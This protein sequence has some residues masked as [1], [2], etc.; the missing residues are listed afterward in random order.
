MN[1]FDTPSTETISPQRVLAALKEARAKLAA[2][3]QAKQ[4]RVAIVG[5][6]GRFPGAETI[7]R[8][9]QNL[10]QGIASIQVLNPSTLNET[11]SELS[12]ESSYSANYSAN[13][14]NAYASFADIAGFDAAF[15]GYSPR[16]AELLDPQHRVFLEC[17]WTALEHAGYDPDRYPGQIGVYAGAGLN[18]YL[19][20]LYTHPNLR[21]SVD[22]VQAVVSNV[23]GLMPTRVSYKL[24]LTG[25][26]C[27]I[28]TGCSTSLVA[29]HLACQ[30]LLNRECDMALAGG[31]S[32]D[33]S[34]QR[35][36]RYQNDGVLSPDG[37]CRAFDAAAQGTVFG[38]GA[39]LVVLKRL[40]EALRDGDSIYAVIKGSAINNDGA[41]KVGLTAPSVTGQA[42]V[43]TTALE[44]ANC[45]P[46]TI[47]YIEAHGTGTALG[48]P[49]EIAALTKAFRQYTQKQQFCAIGSLKTN[50]GHLD[51]AAGIAGL[52]K[53]A[54]ALKH[55]QIPP[56]LNFQSA[57]PQIDFEHSPFYVNTQLRNWPNNSSTDNSPRHAGVSSFGMGGTNA[58]LI[59]EEAPEASKAIS[60]SHSHYL[61][62]LSAK[63]PSALDTSIQQLADHLTQHPDL[64]LADVAYTLQVGRKSFPYRYATV[65][66]T[67]P[68]AIQALQNHAQSPSP[69]STTPPIAFLFPGQGSQYPSM[70]RHLYDHEPIFRHT[71]DHCSSLLLSFLN[72]DLR[73]LLYPSPPISPL[74][75]LTPT[76]HAQPA[77]FVVEYAL[78]QLWRSW[79]IQPTAMIGHSLGE[80]VAAT[81]AGVFDLE[82]ALMIVATRAQLMQQCPAG[83]MLSVG[84]AESEV[85]SRLPA[86]LSIAAVNAPRACVV[87]GVP[88][89]IE[90][91]EQ[92]LTAEGVACRRLHTSHAF[93]SPLMASV[94][95]PLRER[96]KSIALH[97]PQLPFISNL[98]GTWITASEA[99]NPDYWVQH[100]RQ[101][102][103]FA[104]GITELLKKPG[105]VLLEVGPGRTLSTLSKQIIG[106]ATPTLILPSL[107]HPQ[108]QTSDLEILLHSLRQ[109]W[110]AGADIDCSTLYSGSQRRIPLPTYPFE[111]QRY[112][113][114]LQPQ[115]DSMPVQTSV[116]ASV[117][118]PD[119]S[120]WF[121][122]PSWSRST[123]LASTSPQLPS[124]GCW[125]IF[126]DS[127]GIAATLV[128]ALRQAGHTVISVKMGDRFSQQDTVYTID[129]QNQQDYH[130]LFTGLQQSGEPPQQIIHA[131][132]ITSATNLDRPDAGFYSLIALAQ[133]C[134]KIGPISIAVLT[135][136][137]FDLPGATTWEPL[138][139]TLLGACRVIRQECSLPCRIIE[140]DL[141]EVKPEH[142]L[143]ELLRPDPELA[144]AH[145]DQYRWIPIIEPIRL[146]ESNA[147]ENVN[148][149]LL[150]PHQTYLIAGDLVA[151]LGLIFAQCFATVQAKL[152]LIGRVGLPDKQ[153]WTN[154]LNTHG[155]DDSVSRYILSLQSLE[156]QGIELHCFSADLTDGPKL[157]AIVEWAYQQFGP[158]HAAVHADVM[159]DQASCLISSLTPAEIERQFRAKVIGLQVFETVLRGKVSG[160]YLLQ[161]SLSA[162]VGGVGFAAYAA[163]NAFMDAFALQQNRSSAV[164]WIT[165]N[166]DACRLDQ[167]ASTAPTG[168]ALFDLAMTPIEVQQALQRVLCHPELVQI[169]VSPTNLQ[170]RIQQSLRIGSRISS[171]KNSPK[172][173]PV[174]SAPG[175]SNGVNTESSQQSAVTQHSRP[176]LS[177]A[178]V[179]PR[180]EIECT[181]AEA[182]QSL[183][184]IETI[185]IHDNFFEMGGDSLMAIQAVS[186]LRETYQVEL[187]MREFLFES[188]T[189]AGIAKII[190]DNQAKAASS[191]DFQAM[192]DL[193]TQIEQMNGDEVNVS[194]E[195]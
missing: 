86:E 129:P 53:T 7:E 179:A 105:L 122:L 180:N 142:I 146:L 64:N 9:W 69:I 1:N 30:S 167:P 160:F 119:L 114:E 14:I 98:T 126:L 189:V 136:Q 191:T 121:Y 178:Y 4:E 48:D 55:R 182:M 77:L 109:L 6:A 169:A 57:N 73:T 99:T 88:E 68:D 58:H 132:S 108:E 72:L 123:R 171:P 36:Y 79:G 151:G 39:G 162:L 95:D 90:R 137:L 128:A 13:Y 133:A 165:I 135:N 66:Q 152:I 131:W 195:N 29:V 158:I 120:D 163:A 161:S 67:I 15:F 113:I 8:F 110:L 21:N 107:R 96:L 144:V 82:D 60:Q 174:S 187:P 52:I 46:E 91:F 16:E 150:Q 157:R 155:P 139:A 41:Q 2:V 44:R 176:L 23:M 186:R 42:A 26:S 76:H 93:H 63:T 145:R 70:A 168:A 12:T 45:S 106:I 193:L 153:D 156:A 190:A 20:N 194:L 87:S 192:A 92:Q 124:S 80:Y 22:R 101:P 31:V 177:T 116:P 173:S 28:Q 103:R 104:A 81:L 25:P 166:W 172:N 164:P 89:A 61:L 11:N 94:I 19:I 65:C 138:K 54:L 134:Q 115:P 74:P 140:L 97:P 130:R 71:I 47:Q 141:A 37:V 5:M 112:W 102:V 38:N 56:S 125:L 148:S 32:I 34:E 147:E 59:L 51:A 118:N 188:P 40:S 170:Q 184:G 24:N 75:P 143:T 159:G 18:S 183:L 50:I 3:E 10:C 85:A 181:V 154:W 175:Q 43:I 33:A 111:R 17:A 149:T 35:G 84:L 100:L 62:L 83:A 27:G 117:K 185:G 127:E 78:A 49:I